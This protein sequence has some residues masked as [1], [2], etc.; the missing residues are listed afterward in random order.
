MCSSLV[1]KKLENLRVK[2]S[3][4]V[5]VSQCVDFPLHLLVLSQGSLFLPMVVEEDGKVEVDQRVGTGTLGK[6]KSTLRVRHSK[7]KR[8]KKNSL[9]HHHSLFIGFGG[10]LHVVQVGQ[11][12]CEKDQRFVVHTIKL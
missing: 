3:A 5:A 9:I 1:I 2:F 11:S 8:R 12:H 10:V 6:W 7:G 4:A